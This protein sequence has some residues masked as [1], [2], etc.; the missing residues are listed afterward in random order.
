M[1]S[2]APNALTMGAVTR[3]I[4][5]AVRA[6][7]VVGVVLFGALAIL[8][9]AAPDVLERAARGYVSHRLQREVAA[10]RAD[11]PEATRL[12]PDAEL[13]RQYAETLRAAQERLPSALEA[14]IDKLIGCLCKHECESRITARTLFELGLNALPAETRTALENLRAIT[15]GRFDVIFEKLRREL[16]LISTV[17]TVI[18]AFLFLASLRARAWRLVVLPAALLAA[19]TV[20]SLAIYALGTNWWWAILTDGYW[21]WSYLVLDGVIFLIFIDIVVLRG[22]VTGVIMDVIGSAV[23]VLASPC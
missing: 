10:L 2:A 21:G 19:A 13:A 4:T 18:F 11:L 17:N 8:A 6:V 3:R 9:A 22:A 23:P 5:Q 7:A 16:L 20:T 12:L 14:L 15:Q 1:N